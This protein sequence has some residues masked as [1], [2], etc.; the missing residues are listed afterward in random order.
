MEVANSN[1]NKFVM[2]LWIKSCG[3]WKVS[4]K[5]FNATL[6]FETMCKVQFSGTDF[7]EISGWV[8]CY[9]SLDRG[10]VYYLLKQNQQK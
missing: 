7:L 3:L 6:A 4:S 2:C 1:Y 5:I 8:N 9:D 10:L